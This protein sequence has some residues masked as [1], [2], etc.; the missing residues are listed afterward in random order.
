MIELK[1]LIIACVCAITFG[2]LQEWVANKNKADQQEKIADRI[3]HCI[4]MC[5]HVVVFYALIKFFTN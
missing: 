2:G 3:T 4:V 1:F 5:I